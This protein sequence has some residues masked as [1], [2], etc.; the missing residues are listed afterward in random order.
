MESNKSISKQNLSEPI[1]GDELAN[2]KKVTDIDNNIKCEFGDLIICTADESHV[3]EVAELWANL[4]CVQQIFAPQRYDFVAEGKNWQSFVRRKLSKKNNLLLV[5]HN[6]GSV[7]VK[8][9]LYL[10]TVTIPSSDLILKGIIEDLYTKPQYRK[11]EVAFKLLDT[12]THWA[13]SQNIKQIDLIALSK[14]KDLFE[15]YSKIL[16]R[17][18]KNINLELLIV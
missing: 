8:S 7:E 1:T 12:A 6:K 2:L 16:K 9:F 5:A 18:E 3:K 13:Q 4:A 15:F 11:Q 17:I 14:T 10:Q